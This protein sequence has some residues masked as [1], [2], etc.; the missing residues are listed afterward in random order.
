MR[1]T[2]QSPRW[3][4]AWVPLLLVAGS[5]ALEPRI[6]LSPGEH[7]IVRLAMTLLLFGIIVSWLRRNRGALVN[8]AYEHEWKERVYK[9]LQQ[10]R[11]SAIR[12]YEPWEDA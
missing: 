12:A 5:L 8:A 11:E 3:W 7:Q 1:F 4:T 10:R 6:L 2:R 9:S